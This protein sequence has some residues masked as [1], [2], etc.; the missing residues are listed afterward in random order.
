MLSMANF[1]WEDHAVEPK[2]RRP[3]FP[4]SQSAGANTSPNLTMNRVVDCRGGHIHSRQPQSYQPSAT[5]A[6][7]MP[8]RHPFVSYHELKQRLPAESMAYPLLCVYCF[9]SD[10]NTGESRPL[11]V[12]AERGFLRVEGHLAYVQPCGHLAGWSCMEK[13]ASGRCPACGILWRRN[14]P[15]ENQCLHTINI[16]QL[17]LDSP[18]S[19]EET[20]W[21]VPQV[22]GGHVPNRCRL[23]GT[24]EALRALTRIARAEIHS[25][26]G[27][28]DTSCTYATDG[29][30]NGF[31][32][33]DELR[34]FAVLDIVVRPP[35]LTPRLI[36]EAR[37]VE[38]EIR[39]HY[40]GRTPL[41][42]G[43]MVGSMPILFKV[44][45]AAA[46]VAEQGTI[47]RGQSGLGDG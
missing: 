4:H 7:V 11:L 41:A 9:N 28:G 5:T 45:G 20:D 10:N 26:H 13:D 17:R 44:A 1:T 30:V 19:D 24:L 35:I 23:C 27:A 43:K 16:S 3:A 42:E 29:V 47:A 37:A 39:K 25:Q 31:L 22:P 32:D 38:E 36:A 40:D 6:P 12:N 34:P 33:G 18:L 14:G 15:L 21:L 46:P 8:T 2:L